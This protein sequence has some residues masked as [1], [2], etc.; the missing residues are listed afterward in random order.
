MWLNYASYIIIIALQK[1]TRKLL[2]EI[3]LITPHTFNSGE[4]YYFLHEDTATLP[5]EMIDQV[6]DTPPFP[7]EKLRVAIEDSNGVT[8]LMTDDVGIIETVLLFTIILHNRS[9]RY[10]RE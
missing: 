9:G 10:S 1:A 5:I 6:Y 8:R 7:R 3:Q 4:S 2:V